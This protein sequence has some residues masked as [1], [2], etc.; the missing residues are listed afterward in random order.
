MAVRPI[1]AY[2]ETVLRQKAQ[3]V[4]TIDDA[5]QRLID[6]MI[7]TM[8]AAPG[9]GLA[10]P[11]V[12]ISLRLFV[13]DITSGQ[14]VNAL[15]TYINPE[16]VSTEGRIR[17]DEGC[18]SVVGVTGSTPRAER[19]VLSGLNREGDSVEVEADGLLARAFQ[20]EFDHLNGMLFFDRMG[21]VGRD[22][23]KR[24]YKRVQRRKADR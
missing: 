15:Q 5:L 11:Q 2:P 7:E 14:D 9:I 22:L 6:D 8:Y 1:C 19:V 4:E 24:K 10:A 23:M 13:V 21:V 18:L 12:G 20:H 3:P 17:E 16:I